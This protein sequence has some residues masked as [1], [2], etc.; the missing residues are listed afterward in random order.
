MDERASAQMLVHGP[1]L[2]EL[3][4]DEPRP[5]SVLAQLAADDSLARGAGRGTRGPLGEPIGQ[6]LPA[7]PVVREVA[8]PT[9]VLGNRLL[10]SKPNRCVLN[11]KNFV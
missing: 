2:A 8:R 9:A 6:V 4:G 10:W 3:H 5:L 7:R 11:C 1:V